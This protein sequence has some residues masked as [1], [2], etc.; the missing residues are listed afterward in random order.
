M[1][2]TMAHGSGGKS[3]AQL[4]KDI[5]GKHFSNDV[6]AKME[7]AAVLDIPADRIACSTDSFVV[8]PLIF[9]GG[10]IGKLCVCGTVNDLL[11]MGAVPKYLTCGFI[12]EEGLET[13]LLDQI[14]GSMAAQAR[15]A[16]VIIV[17]G[18]TKVVEGSGGMYINTTGIGV[19]P[20]GRDVSSANCREGDVIICSGNLGDHHACILSHRMEI[21]NEITS[22]CAALNDIVDALFAAGIDVRTMRDVTR[23]G[24]GTVI[25]EI[26]ESSAC[27][28]ELDEDSIPVSREVK[29]FS[30][31]LGLDPLYMGNEGK[32]IAV[33]P[34]EQAEKALETMRSTEHGKDAAIIGRVQSGEGA[35][36]KTHLG[37][38]RRFDVLYGEGLPR[39][40]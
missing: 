12:L 30:D 8:T 36:I 33:V 29:G 31:I 14:V 35:F 2:I 40:C 28:I 25:N 4:M 37:A 9:K 19:I 22:D 17:A 1:K 18:D 24:L 11:M 32:M 23:G 34:E 10:D 13:E 3:S 20:E 7:D 21:E 27:R 26:A 38:T 15:D 16:G 6:L 5:F 39:I